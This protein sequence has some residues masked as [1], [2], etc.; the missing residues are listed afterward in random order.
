MKRIKIKPEALF[1]LLVFLIILSWFLIVGFDINME[2]VKNITRK[3]LL[4]LIILISIAV[5]V[6][7]RKNILQAITQNNK[8]IFINLIKFAG[9]IVI[10]VS[11][12]RGGGQLAYWIW[13][14]Y[15]LYRLWLSED[16]KLPKS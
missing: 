3:I 12:I 5:I 10:F 7:D 6:H 9:F 1:N 14:I 8:N 4:L 13:I 15:G 2:P 11:S 16:K